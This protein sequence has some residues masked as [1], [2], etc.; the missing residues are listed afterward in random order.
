MAR[1]ISLWRSIEKKRAKDFWP[2]VDSNSQFSSTAVL[3]QW[4][5]TEQA[6]SV[7][8]D[9]ILKI[10]RWSEWERRTLCVRAGCS[11]P[12]DGRRL[13][14]LEGNEILKIMV[15]GAAKSVKWWCSGA[16]INLGMK[17]GVSRMAHTQY[18][19]NGSAPTG[20]GG[21]ENNRERTNIGS[22]LLQLS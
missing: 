14:Q 18:A 2:C 15:S 21:G 22:P 6:W 16:K 4:A 13:E 12:A 5:A 20:G 8:I 19:H 11:K 7:M 1:C 17:M 9:G 10:H 3:Y